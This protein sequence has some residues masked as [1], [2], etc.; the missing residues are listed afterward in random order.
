MKERVP[1][2]LFEL[3]LRRKHSLM[4]ALHELEVAET[5]ACTVAFFSPD[6][7]ASLIKACQKLTF[8]KAQPVVGNN[9]RQDFDVCFPAP[10]IGAF[11][12]C[13]SL[14]EAGF[15]ACKLDEP[16]LFD[17]DVMLND[18]AV[19]HYPKKSTGIGIHKDGM[20]YRNIVCIINL[21]GS[22]QLFTCQNRDGLDRVDIDD[23]PGQLVLLA[24]PGFRGL[25]DPD[26]RPLHGV[27]AIT[28][29]R[30]SI[31]FRME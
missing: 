23:S 9:V 26:K 11:D 2:P 24:A 25:A 7:I 13:A 31:G 22:S 19:Q 15:H 5:G 21:A 14:L 12:K 20:R 4:A 10:R 28:D 1:M 6:E 3:G 16:D 17:A 18:F 30:L 27:D 8:R 29:G